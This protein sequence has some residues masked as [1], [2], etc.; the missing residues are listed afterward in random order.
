MALNSTLSMKLALRMVRD[1]RSLDY[2]GCL[3]NEINIALNKIQDAEFD[4]G[5]SQV[6]MKPGKH[7]TKPNFKKDV[8]NDEVERFL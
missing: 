1:A 7:G 6:L 4:I 2:K 5:I 8:P 3:Q